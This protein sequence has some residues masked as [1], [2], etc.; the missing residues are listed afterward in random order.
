MD[1]DN[2]WDA[3]LR[4]GEATVYFDRLRDAP[5]QVAATAYSKINAWWLAE[6]CRL[7]YKQGADEGHVSI[8]PPRQQVLNEVGLEEVQFF[9]DHGTQCYIVKT[10]KPAAAQFAALIFR[11]STEGLDWLTN[12]TA[13]PVSEPGRGFVHLGFRNALDRVWNAVQ[14]V[15]DTLDKLACPIFYAGHSLGAAL[16]TL[17][18]SRRPPR[19]LYTFGSP[20]VGNNDFKASL[21]GKQVYRVV[22]NLDLVTTAPP[23]VPFHHLKE[24]HYITHAG[25]MLVDPSDGTVFLDRLKR[26]QRTLFSGSILRPK[27]NPSPL[28]ALADHAPVNYVARLER[29]V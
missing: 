7:V 18:A 21:A 9:N 29:L 5:F 26:D 22:N 8:G 6:L 11:G 13:I 2:S 25:D 14:A 24:L 23:P 16:A 20:R 1:F 3:L 15:L 19:A 28:E 27:P 17:A 12:F 4:P 10:A